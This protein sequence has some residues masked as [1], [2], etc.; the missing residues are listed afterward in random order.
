MTLAGVT[1]MRTYDELVA[2]AIAAPFEG[3]NFSWLKGRIEQPG[4]NW[5]Y[6]DRARA[7]LAA[8]T[9]ALDVGTGGGEL[10]A[11]LQPLPAHTVATEAYEPNIDLARR[12]L[13]PLGVEVRT[14]MASALPAGDGEFDLIVNRHSGIHAGEFRRVLRSGGS[15]LVQA[16]GAGNDAE[17]N[18]A[19]G[20]PPPAFGGGDLETS[21]AALA[22]VGFEI[23]DSLTERPEYGF[24]DVGAVIYHL[25]AVSWQIP[26]FDVYKYDQQLRALDARIRSEGRFVAHDHRYLIEAR[27]P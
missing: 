26:D 2:E 7:A 18:A 15:V 9:S 8:A 4:P 10:L 21:V 17:L 11:S 13:E 6:E 1:T 14:G 27:L 24:Y 12:R 25:R 20:A 5:S 19:L 22:S 3:W 16:V 23:V